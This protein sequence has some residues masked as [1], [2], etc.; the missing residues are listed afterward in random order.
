VSSVNVDDRTGARAAAQH[1][2]DLGHRRIS[3]VNVVIDGTEG[4]VTD[5]L[6]EVAAH[7]PRQRMLGWL[8]ALGPADITPNVLQI[9]DAGT[10]ARE[11][12]ELVLRS[13][14][15]P[16]AVLCFSDVIALEVI[17]HAR[18]LGID[19][20][21]QLSVVGFDDAPVARLSEPP[22]TTV[23]QDVGAK[24]HRAAEAL[25]AALGSSRAGKRTRVRHWTL[26]TELVVRE[27]T[28]RAP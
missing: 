11:A 7:P 23:R 5:P 16:S 4:F 6:V 13:G 17:R 15:E 21:A 26:P 27:T 28:G 9:R 19:V 8:D 12:A 20:P 14:S 1:L 18:E 25:V 22:L 24:G 10:S 3:I 2:V